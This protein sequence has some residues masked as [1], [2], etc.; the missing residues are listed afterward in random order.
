MKNKVLKGVPICIGTSVILLIILLL[1]IGFAVTMGSVDISIKEV[2]EVILY[3]FTNIILNIHDKID[4]LYD[5]NE[6]LKE[7][8]D[9]LIPRLISGEIEV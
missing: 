2:Y 7:A 6:K 9:I 8:R 3:K 4:N 5:Q 1:S